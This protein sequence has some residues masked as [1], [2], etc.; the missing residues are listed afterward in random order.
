MV[1]MKHQAI[2]GNIGRQRGAPAEGL[3]PDEVSLNT[4]SN[5]CS[6]H[7]VPEE[8]E[9]DGE[10]I[11]GD[12]HTL[13]SKQG[14][15][16]VQG[17]R[18][19]G[20]RRR[21]IRWIA[22]VIAPIILNSGAPA[23]GARDQGSDSGT[24]ERKERKEVALIESPEP[25][26][27]TP[28]TPKGRF[29]PSE[30]PLKG[31]RVSEETEKRTAT[32]DEWLNDDGTRSI[33]A[34]AVPHY[35]QPRGSSDW[36]PIETELVAD[37]D[38]PGRV[39][40]KANR[41]SVS[42]GTAGDSE[43]MQQIEL[44]EGTIGFSPI[45]ADAMVEP[46]TKDSTVTYPGLWPSTDAVYA[47]SSV[48]TDE[49][50]VLKA[51]EAPTSFAFEV[52]GAMPRSNEAGGIDL[53]IDETVAATIPPLTV[54]TAREMIRPK[55]AGAE[56]AVKADGRNGGRITISIS[57]EW[58]ASLPAEAFP[59]V[60]DPTFFPMA[61]HTKQGSYSSWGAQTT[62][63]R[64]GRDDWTSTIWRAKAYVPI[65][66]RPT[67]GTEP[68]HLN[69]ATL[70]V[71]GSGFAWQQHFTAWAHF[72]E[73][74]SYDSIADGSK[75]PPY[76]FDPVIYQ[77]TDE[78]K[79][80]ALQDATDWVAARDDTPGSGAWYGFTGWEAPDVE[81]FGFLDGVRVE[82]TYYQS[83][84]PTSLQSPSGTIS[85]TTPFLKAVPVNEEHVYYT[86][87]PS[88]I[89]SSTDHS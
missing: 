31:K 23:V 83:P 68:W 24:K 74:M 20:R 25:E 37:K 35:F 13:P 40:S 78:A 63:M 82:Y 56:F 47:V 45:D 3:P 55:R 88:G 12:V 84:D 41:W 42:F 19:G 14:G 85:T 49:R 34:Y 9:A 81:S 51:P 6:L 71:S 54:E 11:G 59:V 69:R 15:W 22:L 67:G 79:T 18:R 44:D 8:S 57:R 76:F 27:S 2:V 62:D 53:V 48:G 28:S 80:V 1:P 5:A 50:L 33:T 75:L 64:V 26:S 32:S 10:S 7:V 52:T 65:P 60:I 17:Y 66:D 87:A 61:T 77:A 73:P 21:G 70:S 58:L 4:F 39:R 30:P 36:K 86:H 46:I 16:G 38:R 43:G 89:P 29:G 72:L